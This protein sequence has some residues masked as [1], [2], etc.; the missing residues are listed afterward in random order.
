MNLTDYVTFYYVWY[1]KDKKITPHYLV[2]GIGFTVGSPHVGPSPNL[3]GPIH[4]LEQPQL[5]G[6]CLPSSHES[7][8]EIHDRA[9]QEPIIAARNTGR[10]HKQ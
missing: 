1:Q 10:H 9:H 4:L 8:K 2:W 6:P 7:R 5:G 3:S